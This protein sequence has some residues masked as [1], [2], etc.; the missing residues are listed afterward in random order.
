MFFGKEAFQTN[1]YTLKGEG[2]ETYEPRFTY[3]GFRYVELTGYPGRP[4]LRSIEGRVV[5]T[6]VPTAGAFSCSNELVERFYRNIRWGTRGNYLSV[7]I[8]MTEAL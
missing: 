2:V 6:D 4:D 7:G 8:R 1:S 3:H 5:H